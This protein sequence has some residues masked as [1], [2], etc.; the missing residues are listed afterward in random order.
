MLLGSDLNL[1]SQVDKFMQK[2]VYSRKSLKDSIN[3]YWRNNKKRLVWDQKKTLLSIC[4][5]LSVSNVIVPKL[6]VLNT[7]SEKS[8]NLAIIKFLLA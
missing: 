2:Y 7:E 5:D 8:I 6:P 3:K 4:M 1:K